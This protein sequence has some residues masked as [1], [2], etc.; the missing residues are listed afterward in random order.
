MMLIQLDHPIR[1][2]LA[3]SVLV[4]TPIRGK[5]LRIDGGLLAQPLQQSFHHFRF[6][7]QRMEGFPVWRLNVWDEGSGI[8]EELGL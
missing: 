8:R 3:R 5:V 4:R 7:D 2:D 1:I 6:V